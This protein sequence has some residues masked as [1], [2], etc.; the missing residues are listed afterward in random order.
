LE[1]GGAQVTTTVLYD[2][3]GSNFD[4]DVQKAVDSKPDAVAV[5]G[6]NDD[7]AKII[8]TMIGQGAGP[9]QVP[10]YTADG[11]QSSKFATT[12]DPADPSKVSGIKGTA[13]AGSPQGIESPFTAE[14]AAT[15]IDPIFSAYYWDCTN[16][17][18]LAAVKAKSDEGSAIQENFAANL[19]GDNDC[20]NFKD[21]KALLEGGKTIH[22]RGAS[23]QFNKWNKMEPGTGVYEIWSYGPDGKVVTVKDK[24][25]PIG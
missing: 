16:L 8:N 2:P 10:I 7:G 25:I 21:C 3:N 6:F 18:A 9:S 4:A 11:M 24:Q 12:V 19:E 17:M 22:Y 5:I 13:P 1:D 23:S 20:N 15:G 14:F